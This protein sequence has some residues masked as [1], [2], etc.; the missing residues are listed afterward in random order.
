MVKRRPTTY[1]STMASLRIAT[2]NCRSLNCDSKKH[3]AIDI[4]RNRKLDIICLQ[5][6][7]ITEK[8]ETEKLTEI[9]T[10]YEIICPTTSSK[11][12][13]VATLVRR[14]LASRIKA[15]IIM[16][17]RAVAV[18]FQLDGRE[19]NIVNVYVPNDPNEQMAFVESLYEALATRRNLVL[20]G[21]FNH[22][23][24][25][26]ADRFPPSAEKPRKEQEA[27]K[28]FYEHLDLKELTD[29]PAG[30]FTWTSAK[31]SS[32]IDRIY[33]S[34]RMSRTCKEASYQSVLTVT[35][36]DH[37]MVTG[38]IKLA[39]E[40]G[41]SRPTKNWKL[42]SETLKLP[43]VDGMI[44]D[45]LRSYDCEHQPGDVSWY[46]E[47][48][49]KVRRVLMTAQR[50]AAD[51]RS[52]GIDSLVEEY[53]ALCQPTSQPDNERMDV[54]KR[55]IEAFYS[56]K[57]E[58]VKIQDRLL[59]KRFFNMPT[60]A[61]LERVNRQASQQRIERLDI[62]GRVTESPEEIERHLDSFYRDLY[63]KRT[64]RG[65]VGQFGFRMKTISANTSDQ[66]S[67]DFGIGE[68]E[69]VI[70]GLQESSPGLNGLTSAFFKRYWKC[71]GQLLLRLINAEDFK[72][73]EQF[74][75]SYMK[76]LPKTRKQNMS[77]NDFRPITISNVDYRIFAKLL[78]NRLK[79]ANDEVFGAYQQCAMDDRKPH[80]LLYLMT[81]LIHDAN[82]FSRPLLVTSIDQYKAFDMIDHEYLKG[83]LEHVNIG[84]RAQR[85]VKELYKGS[86]TRLMVNGRLTRD[87][88]VTNGLKQGCPLSMWLYM[89]CIEEALV[90]IDEN[91]KIKGYEV[92]ILDKNEVKVRAYAD[93][94]TLFLANEASAELA[95]EELKRWGAVSGAIIN[96]KK[97]QVMPVK[98]RRKLS[99]FETVDEMKVL[100]ITFDRTGPA[101]QNTTKVINRLKQDIFLWSSAKMNVIDRIVALK[102][103]ILS[104][105]WYVASFT[106][107]TDGQLKEIDRYLHQFV[108]DSRMETVKRKTIIREVKDGGLGMVC[109]KSKVRSISL[110]YFTRA[111]VKYK[112]IEYQFAIRWFKTQ[113]AKLGI[114][115]YN[116]ITP[117]V[118]KPDFI[119][120]VEN[121][122]EAYKEAS[123]G[124]LDV[125]EIGRRNLKQLYQ[126]Y[127]AKEMVRPKC[128]SAFTVANWPKVYKRIHEKDLSTKYRALNYRILMNGLPTCDKFREKG[129]CF[130]CNTKRTEDIRH[131]LVECPFSQMIFSTL[132][133]HGLAPADLTYEKIV[134]NGYEGKKQRLVASKYKHAI[135]DARNKS[136]L[137]HTP[138]EKLL[139]STAHSLK[140]LI[141]DPYD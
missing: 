2:L 61:V 111:T 119:K 139:K 67:K 88:M 26:R 53:N 81:G 107:F 64:M 132:A 55:E 121:A 102:A 116:I 125:R 31:A 108:W 77:A 115:N 85:I 46:D 9:A 120:Q 75:R 73:P 74:L 24:D 41:R 47:M 39:G 25:N 30:Q 97:T 52:F 34:N 109:L 48:V 29:F 83:A 49:S 134:L 141:K 43:G 122:I 22:V 127:L 63:T 40:D 13:G 100:G 106:A 118:S 32:R 59:K 28:K 65:D 20:A 12:R 133:S 1:L 3:Q 79:K 78:V 23:V 105:V 128:E 95:I 89:V 126:E 58:S 11:A 42:N 60:K 114:N 56:R 71:Y 104:K 51:L 123:K 14:S 62:N 19:I 72:P 124:K 91:K 131:L 117:L 110:R 21:D 57:N 68:L 94:V 99:A 136:R 96:D 93:D 101:K 17:E 69:E 82:V 112:K 90:R 36:T 80:D 8:R 27:W 135:W 129:K 4:I 86:R 15:E 5:E 92:R 140:N 33:I 137:E 10:E 45:I 35:F 130:L 84:P 50:R 87:I 7:W 16:S 103:F 18:S 113:M 44:T 138:L 76:L 70:K 38:L 37:K 98:H 6:T 54:V 66:L